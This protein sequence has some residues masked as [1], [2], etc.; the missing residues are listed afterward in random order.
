MKKLT[1]EE[2]TNYYNQNIFPYLDEYESCRKDL[3]K[4]FLITASIIV[5]VFIILVLFGVINQEIIIRAAIFTGGVIF[6]IFSFF[7]QIFRNKLKRTFYIQLFSLLDLKYSF[8]SSDEKYNV[9]DKILNLCKK[10]EIYSRYDNIDVDDIITGK[11]NDLDFSVYD[12]HIYYETGSGKNRHTVHPLRGFILTTEIKK[13]FVG[14]TLIKTDRFLQTGKIGQK[15]T[16][17]LED[18]VFEKEF[19]VYS[20]D[21]I[22]GR[23]LLTTAFMNR[24]VEYKKRKHYSIEV[25][26]S[27][28]L[29]GNENIFFFINNN[30]DNFEF[31]MLKKLEKES[32]YKILKEIYDVL[33]IIDALKLEQNIGL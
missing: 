23:Y 5:A 24:L 19:E 15:V 28:N 31:P 4:K 25:F 9:S 1:E 30:K 32:F 2:F 7:R 27:N 21:Q 20:D 3:I 11:Y 18:I 8:E 17:R 10:S 22:E 13:K 26:F 12:T 33:E 14:E 29:D 6:I 16:V